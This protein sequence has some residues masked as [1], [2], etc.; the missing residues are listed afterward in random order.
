VIGATRMT[1]TAL[2][3]RALQFPTGLELEQ[4]LAFTRLMGMRTLHGMFRQPDPIVCEVAATPGALRWR[5]GMTGREAG[6]LL[7]QLRT[8]LPGLAAEPVD[9]RALPTTDWAIELRLDS[10]V[11]TLRTD[12]AEPLAAALLTAISGVYGDE[13]LVLSWVIGPRLARPAVQRGDRLRT[14]GPPLESEEATALRAKLAEP[15]LGVAGRI[16]V[17]AA[18]ASRQTLL[19]QRVLGALELARAPGVT[20]PAAPR[21]SRR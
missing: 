8:Q 7:P 17:H 2:T 12:I 5:L 16:G 20:P 4:A 3:W 10:K 21:G 6:T 19:L 14:F 9:D 1:A 13:A 15:V 11:R 18:T